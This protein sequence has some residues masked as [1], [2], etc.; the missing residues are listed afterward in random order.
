MAD[1]DR[2]VVLIAGG[3]GMLGRALAR[4]L[5]P[6]YA[7][8]G[9]DVQEPSSDVPYHSFHYMDVTSGTS[10]R[11]ALRQIRK[12]YGTEL[13]AVVQLVD[14][15]GFADR[16]LEE[17][18]TI[19]GTARLLRMLDDFEV[20]RFIFS[21]TML[22][23]APVSPGE[24]IREDSPLDPRRPYARCKAEIEELIRS[25]RPAV[26]YTLV[27]AA[28]LYDGFGRHPTLIRQI[29]RI[30]DHDFKSHFVP[31]VRGAGQSMVHVDDAAEALARAVDRRS[32]LQNGPILIGE[33]DPP[34]YA[35]VRHTIGVLLWGERWPTLHVPGSVARA[36]VWLGERGSDERL[37]RPDLAET[38]IDHFALD[39]GR[40]G[41]V[42]G[43]QPQHRLI[44]EL[45]AMI[46]RMRKYPVAWQRAN[47]L[48]GSE[49]VE[50]E[51]V[52]P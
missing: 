39:I 9:A 23:H 29:E 1:G 19:E 3:S 42:L 15:F 2:P 48:L 32:E 13:A 25:H 50:P 34:T 17:E 22:V 16:P 24:T 26:P 12:A 6:G 37:H 49:L 33:P 52:A 40:A 35:E 18:A 47:G 21:S 41:Q 30:K 5:Q 11:Y 14:D 31:S 10:V 27:R 46:E 51:L 7:S 28:G 38:T 8:V 4:V 20:G 36:A 43:W 45:P 44:D